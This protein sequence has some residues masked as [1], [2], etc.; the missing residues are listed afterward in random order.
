VKD[1]KGK[2]VVITGAGSGIGKYLAMLLAEQGCNL[3]LNDYDAESLAETEE[4]AVEFGAKV[5]TKAFDVGNRDANFE[6]ADQA[7]ATL[8]PA[9]V[10]INNA[11][12][13]LGK[14][15]IEE[16]S[17]EDFQWIVNINMWGVIHGS[18]AFLSQLREQPQAN[19]VNICSSFGMMG[20]P[21][22][23]PYSAT[24]FA[25]RG[26][27][28]SIRLELMDT[29]ITCCLVFPG[30][31][32]TN[33]VENARH[34]S[35][36]DKSQLL[37]VFDKMSVISAEKAA[38]KIVNGIRKNREKVVLGDAYSFAFASLLPSFI[39]RP[40]TRFMMK[41]MDQI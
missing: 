2:T 6:F 39:L 11:G 8:G 28:E 33:I 1:L 37:R 23:A 17:Y 34:R 3:A 22:Q 15:A 5:F 25:V 30:G 38:K 29:K 20:V 16:V 4:L 41:K 24:K 7:K 32:R 21:Y 19:L 40:A 9:D 26:F 10:V 27:T 14:M 13:S 35:A 18:T 12:V 36:D 31:V